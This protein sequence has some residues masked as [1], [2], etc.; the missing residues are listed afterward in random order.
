[1]NELLENIH[2]YIDDNGS[3]VFTERYLLERGHCCNNGCKHCPYNCLS[4]SE[5]KKI[6][7]HG[8]KK[9]SIN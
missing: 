4:F 6:N 5:T 2:Y 8:N 3:L 7:S 1:M 9:H